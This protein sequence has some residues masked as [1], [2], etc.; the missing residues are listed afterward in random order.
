MPN[1][2]LISLD[3]A[4][5]SYD[6]RSAI[7]RRLSLDINLGDI[8]IVRGKSGSGKTTLAKALTGLLMPD[9][10]G[11]THNSKASLIANKGLGLNQELTLLENAELRFLLFNNNSASFDKEVRKIITFSELEEFKHEPL[12]ALPSLLRARFALSLY[13]INRFDVVV[14]DENIGISDPSFRQ[15]SRIIIEM[16]I[17]NSKAAV[18]F[19]RKV[20]IFDEFATKEYQIEHGLLSVCNY[21]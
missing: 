3:R 5:F 15:K 12:K 1:R 6:G 7:I 2:N 13:L 18:I 4:S 8:I 10:G 14:I 21:V 17:K 9:E 11:I 16:L 20:S 19:T